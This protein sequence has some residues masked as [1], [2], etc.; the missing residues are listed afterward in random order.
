VLHFASASQLARKSE[1]RLAV[2]Q[3]LTIAVILLKQRRDEIRAPLTY[4]PEVPIW[5]DPGNQQSNVAPFI[6][7]LIPAYFFVL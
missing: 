2:R 5:L 6:E 3:T 1:L 4:P 7:L